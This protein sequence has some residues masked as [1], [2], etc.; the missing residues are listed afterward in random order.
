MPQNTQKRRSAS[1]PLLA[2]L[3]DA[4]VR[5]IEHEGETWYSAE[6][7]V[8][9]LTDSDHP[10]E[11]WTDLKH[12][13]PGLANIADRL[14]MPDGSGD[15]TDAV[16]LEGVLRMVQSISSAA[17]EKIK[18]WEARAARERVEELEDPELAWVRLQKAYG[19]RGYSHPWV[20]K[21]LRGMSAR[22]ELVSEWARR[23]V[24]ESEEYRQLTN[25]I[26]ETAFGMD[27]NR[28]RESKD[29]RR[30]SQ[31]LRDHM[32]DL[33]LTLTML[34]ETAAVELHRDHNSQGFEQLQADVKSAG[35]VARLARVEIERRAGRSIA[36]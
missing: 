19:N 8:R 14:E 23:G 36:A 29:L 13:E 4:R 1:N 30:A 9:V 35:E 26:M 6:D 15:V 22:Q 33:E 3:E 18:K 2:I 17:A 32:T 7:I 28:Y 12:R 25:I 21:R 20:Q 5:W 11:F 34:A 27:V 10:A 31:N 24:K 16:T